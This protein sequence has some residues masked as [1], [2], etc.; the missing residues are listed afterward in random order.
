M[1]KK[2]VSLAMI[3]M[4]LVAVSCGNKSDNKAIDS[5]NYEN[6]MTEGD[7][8]SDSTEATEELVAEDT[9]VSTAPQ[10]VE[11]AVE[12][13][14]TSKNSKKIDQLLKNCENNIHDIKQ[15][16]YDSNGPLSMADLQFSDVR[17]WRRNLVLDVEKLNSLK[18]EMSESQAAKFK[19]IEQQANKI[20]K[21]LEF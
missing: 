14:Q 1:K 7:A 20:F 3:G 15:E 16:G 19:K 2:I 8:L 10:V 9:T 17:E 11:E 12:T 21:D 5:L 6:A 18:S 13:T 4:A